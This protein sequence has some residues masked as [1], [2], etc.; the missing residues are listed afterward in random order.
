MLLNYIFRCLYEYNICLPTIVEFVWLVFIFYFPLWMYYLQISLS[1]FPGDLLSH[2]QIVVVI[3]LPDTTCCI[4]FS[5]KHQKNLDK[6]RFFIDPFL[7]VEVMSTITIFV[8]VLVKD[9]GYNYNHFF[10]YSA[11]FLEFSYG[12]ISP[13]NINPS[14][15]SITKKIGN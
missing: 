8:F 6:F 3:L 10:F 12:V 14:P 15:C 5:L 11:S 1:I 4:F 2:T 9:K 13:S 7:K